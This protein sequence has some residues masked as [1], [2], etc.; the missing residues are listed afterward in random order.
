MKRKIIASIIVLALLLLF[1]IF[2]CS[3]EETSEQPLTERIENIIEKISE[4]FKKAPAV[5]S[6]ET[7]DSVSE[8]EITAPA[9]DT[10]PARA[11]RDVIETE[12]ERATDWAEKE[13]IPPLSDKLP[14]ASMKQEVP[15][16]WPPVADEEEGVPA[17]GK[18]ESAAQP[19]KAAVVAEMPDEPAIEQAA[20]PDISDTEPA[21]LPEEGEVPVVFPPDGAPAAP[22]EKL[23][24]VVP[25]LRAE[26]EEGGQ[27]AVLPGEQVE[28]PDAGAEEMISDGA[29]GRAEDRQVVLSGKEEELAEE[30]KAAAPDEAEPAGE[31]VQA[32]APAGR[33]LEYTEEATEAAHIEE[34]I[35]VDKEGGEIAGE[36]DVA[37][38]ASDVTEGASL[39]AVVFK[40]AEMLPPLPALSAM[41]F[42]AAMKQKELSKE[43]LPADEE[44][45]VVAAGEEERAPLPDK[46]AAVAEMPD[47]PAIEQAAGPDISDTEPAVLPEE[48]EVP[49]V[50]PPEGAPAAPAEEL[51]PVV[52]VLRA[53]G[54]EGGQEEVLPGEQVELPDAGAEEMI[55]DGPSDRAEDRQVVLSGKE[56]EL[57]EE[58]KAAA[59]AEMAAEPAIERAAEADIP[60][61]QAILQEEGEVPVVLPPEDAPVAPV[62]KM[63]PAV[64]A[65][66][67][68]GVEGGQD[69]VL[70][71]EQVQAAAPAVRVLEQTEE[72]TEAGKIEEPIPV[73]EEGGAIAGEQEV[74][75]EASDV[76]EGASL[77]AAGFEGA[78]LLPPLPA[79]GG[80][81]VVPG[82]T[83]PSLVVPPAGGAAGGADSILPE[84]EGETAIA[85]TEKPLLKDR[86]LAQPERKSAAPAE[87]GMKVGKAGQETVMF[88]RSLAY[89]NRI[90]MLPF[91]NMSDEMDAEKY[92]TP[93]LMDKI[94]N[95][96][97]NA[98]DEGTLNAFL[99]EQRVRSTGFVSKELAGKIR[100]RFKASYILAGSILSFSQETVPRFGV[101]A[102]LIDTSDGTILWADYAA[103]TGEDFETILGLG[104]LDTIFSLIPSV[105]DKLF[106]SFNFQELRNE[107]GQKRKIAIIPLKNNSGFRNAGVIAM[108]MFMIEL[109]KTQEYMPIEY[110]NIRNLIISLRI[111]NKGELSYANMTA[112]SDELGARGI[113]VGVVDNYS[114]GTDLL[115][116]PEVGLT[117]RLV[118]T[119]NNKILWY[120]SGE[121]SGE[122]GI[123]AL[124]W[125]RL[126]TVHSVAYTVVTRLVEK[127]GA[128]NW[129]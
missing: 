51:L 33:E 91:E 67:A 64:P 28:L 4:A 39:D 101:L 57:A 45:G 11:G 86:S 30:A 110:G 113:L 77:D 81:A 27:E 9:A 78:D 13:I 93:V 42:G 94:E 128:A 5:P 73:D 116:P 55:S 66:R 88:D 76:T 2:T 80:V 17:A 100:A 85:L 95:M 68:E 121:L 127:M 36:Q 70:P 48:G 50:F 41:A 63:L 60:A 79:A 26:G 25:V 118:D 24:P 22:A 54:E 112:L 7:V 58:A 19:D 49:V 129:Q 32:E 92:L 29:S 109:L 89:S 125:G 53:E 90:A 61:E 82:V 31:Q 52:P 106:A 74:A 12:A 97:L 102:R 71:G 6:R 43:A 108:H 16:E 34:P 103:A 99:C 40:G 8:K 115:S 15:A 1:I 126:R 37:D 59:V 111:R 114:D 23:L 75:A 35:A 69:A 96:G 123:I 124:D 44:E 119:R 21:E 117:M 3:R 84:G 10:E 87:D 18:E 47:E 62:E 105:T 104:R 38:A 56:E 120:N 83:V 72:A 98:V 20:E 46:A 122:E 107:K 14:A 65:L